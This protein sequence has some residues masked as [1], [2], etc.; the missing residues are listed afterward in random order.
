[1]ST[2][3]EQTYLKIWEENFCLAL[4]K[5]AGAPVQSLAQEGMG[6]LSQFQDRLEDGVWFR[7]EAS[8]Q[9]HGEQAFLLPLTAARR[10]A[11]ILLEEDFD[12]EAEFNEDYRSALEEFFRGLASP[13]A[14]AFTGVFGGE[15]VLE[16][17]GSTAP[18]WSPVL[19]SGFQFS[20]PQFPPVLIGVFGSRKLV[21]SLNS[22]E[23]PSEE[24]APTE[25]GASVGAIVSESGGAPNLDLLK[26]VELAVT[27]R[28]GGREMLL[29]D[30][31]ELNTGAVIELDRQITEPAELFVAD[32][33]VARG[34]VVIVDGNYGLR[35]TEVVSSGQRAAAL[36][37]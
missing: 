8:K 2:P 28:F 19:Q 20:C 33:L 36:Q 11:Q 4:E 31:L 32:K 13:V 34:E 26:E 10:L 3:Q 6:I 9:F 1:M 16:F 24:K 27:L 12:D 21:D 25:G 35:V 7:L 22:L 37:E 29:R 18:A 15:V 30:I 5:V 23:G 17:S 14:E